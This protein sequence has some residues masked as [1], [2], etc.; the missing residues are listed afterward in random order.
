MH[1]QRAPASAPAG[2]DFVP[3]TSEFTI[4]TSLS[5]WNASPLA[6][7]PFTQMCR[8]GGKELLSFIERLAG[9]SKLKA[10]AEEAQTALDDNREEALSLETDV[11]ESAHARRV[12]Q[13]QVREKG[14][15]IG[16][17]RARVRDDDVRSAGWHWPWAALPDT[18][19][20]CFLEP[21]LY[22]R[23]HL[24]SRVLTLSCLG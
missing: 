4:R 12:L 24:K 18:S 7:A 5:S 23:I 20:P 8:R 22:G 15:V 13:P 11:Q 10:E 16:Y 14:C 9:T 2:T 21:P 3:L 19:P 1:K 17:P 6:Y